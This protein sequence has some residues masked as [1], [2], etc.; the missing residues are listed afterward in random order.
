MERLIALQ[1]PIKSGSEVISQLVF[2]GPLKGKHMKG[3]PLVLHYDHLLTLAGRLCGQP[4]HVM[5]ELSGPDLMTTLEVV[6]S[7][8]PFGQ[9][10]GHEPLD[11]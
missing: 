11:T 1:A 8:L 2:K 7:F 5:D 9:K 4:P 6:S 3:L 10:T